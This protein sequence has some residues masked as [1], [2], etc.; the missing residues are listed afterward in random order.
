M[1]DEASEKRSFCSRVSSLHYAKKEEE[2][3]VKQANNV[4]RANPVSDI[5]HI[6]FNED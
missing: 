1:N 6:Q 2:S 5:S 4:K 3:A